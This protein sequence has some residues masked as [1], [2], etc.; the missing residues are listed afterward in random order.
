MCC[1]VNVYA[2]DRRLSLQCRSISQE[3]VIAVS[4]FCVNHPLFYR[5]LLKFTLELIAVKNLGHERLV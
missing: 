1:A 2:K 4:A 3:C 5:F